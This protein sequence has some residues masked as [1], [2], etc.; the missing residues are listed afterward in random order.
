MK[1]KPNPERKM[2]PW[3][4]IFLS[5][6]ASKFALRFSYIKGG[7]HLSWTLPFSSLTVEFST[8]LLLFSFL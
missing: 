6:G 3:T 4:E 8:Y 2:K 1:C 5:R 7:P